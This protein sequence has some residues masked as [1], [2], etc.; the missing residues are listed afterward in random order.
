MMNE[1]RA[2][3]VVVVDD[4]PAIVSAVCDALELIDLVAVGCHH[5]R[6]AQQ[7]IRATQ[8]RVTILDVQMPEVDGIEL[9]QSMRAD[10]ATTAIP[11]IFLTANAH[12]VNK[13][14]PDYAR[15]GATILAKPY[16]IG[17]LFE[18]VARFTNK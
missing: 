14:L 10:P 3:D 11:V 16:K 4:E 17:A 1:I 15:R 12:V 2:T 13:R 9:F 8:P 5:G 6:G 18:M 7:C